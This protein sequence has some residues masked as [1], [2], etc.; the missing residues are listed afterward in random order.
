MSLTYEICV[1]GVEGTIAAER[2]GAHRVELCAALFEGG[3]TPSLGMITATMA[4]VSS[5]RVYVIIRPRGGDFIYTRHEAA[6]MEQDVVAARQAGVHGVV[7]GALT[8]E[9]EVDRPLCEW[10][11]E[12]AGGLPLTFHRAFDMTADPFAA[13]ETLVDLGIHRVLTSGQDGSA[14]EG[15]PL[16]A[17]LVRAAGD[18][19][20]VM[21]GGGITDRNAARIVAAT[22][23]SELHFS[24][25]RDEPGPAVFRNPRPHMGG[26]L[27]RPEYARKVT[28]AEVISSV[29]ASASG[30]AHPSPPA[31]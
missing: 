23:V 31:R 6:A 26:A 13:L 2:S 15:A 8:R 3:I 10:L 9:G 11:V 20:I 24:A 25:F 21:A 17:E 16:I 7:I 18:R 22:G 5:I 1:D 12:A 27:R 30:P 14:L 29:I 28:S 19:I 4:A